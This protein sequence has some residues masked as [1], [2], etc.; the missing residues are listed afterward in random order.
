MNLQH[1]VSTNDLGVKLQSSGYPEMFLSQVKLLIVF[2]DHIHLSPRTITITIT[3]T[4]AKIMTVR[5][6]P[7]VRITR[8]AIAPFVVEIERRFNPGA[9]RA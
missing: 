6:P 8:F 5:G 3:I 9:G 2:L 7:R 1:Y 4:T